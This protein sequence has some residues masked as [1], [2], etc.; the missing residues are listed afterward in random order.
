MAKYHVKLI[1]SEE[2]IINAK[3]EKKAIKK[4]KEKFGYNYLVDDVEIV[5][6]ERK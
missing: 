2:Y 6:V 5:K 1:M 3:S 4:A